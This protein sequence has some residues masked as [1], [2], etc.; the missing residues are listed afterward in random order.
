MVTC[1]VIAFASSIRPARMSLF[2][3]FSLALIPGVTNDG[4]RVDMVTVFSG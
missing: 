2:F 4:S 3:I 1:T